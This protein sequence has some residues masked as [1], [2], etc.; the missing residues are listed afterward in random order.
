MQKIVT[1]FFEWCLFNNVGLCISNK[2]EDLDEKIL[3]EEVFTE[4]KEEIEIDEND[5]PM[6]NFLKFIEGYVTI[7]EDLNDFVNDR[8]E[9]EEEDDDNYVWVSKYY[10]KK[11]LDE[12][13]S[14]SNVPELK[15]CLFGLN[16]KC[17]FDKKIYVVRE[18]NDKLLDD[19]KQYVFWE[20]MYT[21]GGNIKIMIKDPIKFDKESN[22][23]ILHVHFTTEEA[24]E[25]T[26]KLF[27]SKGQFIDFT[28]EESVS[29]KFRRTNKVLPIDKNNIIIGYDE[30]EELLE[31]NHSKFEVINYMHDLSN[32]F[33]LFKET[34]INKQENRIDL[35]KKNNKDENELDYKPKEIELNEIS[36]VDLY[37]NE[38]NNQSQEL[39][40][41]S[42]QNKEEG[43]DLYKRDE[44]DI[45]PQNDNA[46]VIFHNPCVALSQGF[47]PM[48]RVRIL[49]KIAIYDN[50]RLVE[51]REEPEF[52]YF[53]TKFK[54]LE[55]I[56]PTLKPLCILMSRFPNDKL[57]IDLVEYLA[58][59]PEDYDEEQVENK[60]KELM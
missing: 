8:R 56:L 44:I 24:I 55:K 41:Y 54:K 23:N 51:T 33:P 16:V 40:L 2:I 19:Y 39:N 59:L 42:N 29:D 3:R 10:F 15:D 26:V 31:Q 12:L 34:E 4:T 20:Y 48:R 18:G 14:D 57:M 17:Y 22:D 13:A 9:N 35:Y 27:E 37:S 28:T 50:N 53:A 47:L 30:M 49:D 11:I 25:D 5:I 60:L 45:Y 6:V 1:E 43:I 38:K 21:H 58:N 36:D 32:K 52:V 7:Y 46:Q